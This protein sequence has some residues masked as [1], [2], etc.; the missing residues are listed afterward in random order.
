ML[1]DN[2]GNLHVGHG[3]NSYGANPRTLNVGRR[4]GTPNGAFA[5][6]GG[7]SIG[8]GTGPYMEMVHGPDGGTQRVHQMYSYVGNMWITPDNASTF[9]IGTAPSGQDFMIDTSGNVTKPNNPSFA[10]YKS[11][12]QWNLSGNDIM[13]FGTARH[14]VGGHYN[15]S[16]GRFTA[17]VAG[18]Y[19][20][21]FYSI[22]LYNYN[23]ASVKMYKN[24]TR[25]Y[26]GDVHFTPYS[27]GNNQW[28]NVSFSNVFQ[29]AANDYIEMRNG[30]TA[31]S[32]HG[33]HWHSF[34][35]YLLG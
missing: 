34:C 15:T 4:T 33:N 35:G 13:V 3:G 21:T 12:S 14:N 5:L 29:L 18:S 24:G 9:N 11:Q 30:S 19:L 10:V 6:A 32:Y 17:P 31:V 8:G 22:M 7:E 2:I 16:N 25:Q 27:T 23:S 26:G 28:D 1:L 20:F